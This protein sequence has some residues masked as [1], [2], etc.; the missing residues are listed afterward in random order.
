MKK[1]FTTSL[2]AGGLLLANSTVRA[3]V[4]FSIGPKVGCNRSFG[5]FEYPN[6]D[7]LTVTNASRNG[8][9]A[10]LMAQI[11]FSNHWA[12]QPAVL[13]AQKGFNFVEKAYDSRYNYAYQGDYSFRFDY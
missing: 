2:L 6:Q 7:Y 4:S 11:G 1:T 5:P 3:Q 9:E 13:Y 8:V 10:G 12:V